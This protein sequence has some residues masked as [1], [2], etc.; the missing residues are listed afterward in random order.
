MSEI[1]NVLIFLSFSFRRFFL[2]FLLYSGYFFAIV[3]LTVFVFFFSYRTFGNYYLFLV[4]LAVLVVI[5]FLVK[6]GLFLKRQLALN[7]MFVEFLKNKGKKVFTPVETKE[8]SLKKVKE[9]KPGLKKEGAG[10]IPNKLLLALR[11]LQSGG[12]DG[13]FSSGELKKLKAE[14]LKYIFINAIIFLIV[15]IPFMLISF[16]FTRGFMAGIQL[17]IYLLGFSFVYFLNSAVFEP[18]IYLI[19][20]ARAYGADRRD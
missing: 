14:T 13:S 3:A 10:F 12:E 16:F 5:H 15:L 19:I 7:I 17:L 2:N 4:V 9:M 8:L 6:Q 20:Q 11:A 18:I 1:N